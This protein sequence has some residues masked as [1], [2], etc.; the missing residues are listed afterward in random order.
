MN[1]TGNFFVILECC[2]DPDDIDFDCTLSASVVNS[3]L[4]VHKAGDLLKSKLKEGNNWGLILMPSKD[5]LEN[6]SGLRPDGTLHLRITIRAINLTQK[7]DPNMTVTK[8]SLIEL[9]NL[10]ANFNDSSSSADDSVFD[11]ITATS[12]SNVLIKTDDGMA[13]KAN[14]S[15]LSEKS[16]VFKSM[17]TIDMEEAASKSVDIIEFKGPVMRELIRFIYFGK[18]R[19]LEQINMELYKAA[20][21]YNVQELR[22][23]C[24]KSIITEICQENFFDVVQFAELYDIRPVF[25][26]C[27]NKIKK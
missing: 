16:S 14:K 11:V 15:V 8:E 17:F 22:E 10:N 25:D 4:H 3:P 1:D 12:E 26:Y 20:E 21:V 24:L 18:V 5:L 6:N 27:C 23:I 19:D 2:S 7:H 9:L 13:L